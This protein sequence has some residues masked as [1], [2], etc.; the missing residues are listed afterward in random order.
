MKD[1][2]EEVRGLAYLCLNCGAC[3]AAFGPFTPICPA[4]ERFGFNAY[5]SRGRALIA[6]GLAEG[7]LKWTE[8]LV[9]LLYEC[10]GCGGCTSQCPSYYAEHATLVIEALRAEA[11]RRGLGPLTRQRWADHVASE[12]N[13]YF[14]PAHQ[15]L[16]WLPPD[17][18]ASLPRRAKIVYF[19]GCTASYRQREVAQATYSLLKEAG[20]DFTILEGEVCCGSPLLRTGQWDVVKRLAERNIKA[21]EEARAELLVT[22]CAGCYRTWTLDYAKQYR[23]R[24]G[25]PSYSFEVLHITQLLVKLLRE[26]SLRLNEVR[27]RV[28]YHDPCHLGRHSGVYEEPR[29]L[30]ES[31]PGVEL[32]EMERSRENTWCCGAG[33]GVKAGFPEW[34]LEVAVKRLREAEGV[35]AEILTTSCPFCKRNLSD[36]AKA[37]G[38]KLKVLDVVELVARAVGDQRG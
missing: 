25:I 14:E 37:T 21:V 3:T 6:Q 24:L 10:T 1:L 19:V 7:R 38:S 36:A 26:G 30:I 13:P 5:F 22:S 27:A 34:A 9:K 28:A 8:G 2:L 35:G 12:G 31:I 15:R 4:G 18:K 16:S 20:L 33:G 17:E 32:L 23:S 11:V 29:L